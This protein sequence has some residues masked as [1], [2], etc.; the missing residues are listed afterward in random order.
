M[1]SVSAPRPIWRRS[2]A[3][4]RRRPGGRGRQ[5]GAAVALFWLAQRALIA[6]QKGRECRGAGEGVFSRVS[7]WKP[8]PPD[9]ACSRRLFGPGP[10]QPRLEPGREGLGD[11]PAETDHRTIAATPGLKVNGRPGGIKA[12]DQVPDR[13]AQL[14]DFLIDL[15]RVLDDLLLHR[16]LLAHGITFLQRSSCSP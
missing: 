9:S 7:R 8:A 12:V 5:P 14:N 1:P 6:S 4:P 13:H 2:S 10:L 16:L 15:L 3:E 11:H